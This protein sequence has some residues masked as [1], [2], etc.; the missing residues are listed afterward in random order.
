[1]GL[2]RSEIVQQ[3]KLPEGLTI[4]VIVRDGQPVIPQSDTVLQAGDLLYILEV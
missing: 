3:T 4:A 1:M 2:T